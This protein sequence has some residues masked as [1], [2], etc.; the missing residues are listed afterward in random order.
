MGGQDDQKSEPT[1]SASFALAGALT[2]LTPYL[3]QA[4]TCH[5]EIARVQ[6]LVDASVAGTAE[7]TDLRESNFATMHRQPTR[8]S[9][10]KA[11]AEATGKAVALLDQAR[12]EEAAGHNAQCLKTLQIYCDAIARPDEF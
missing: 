4:E 8:E 9:V 5:D 7:I 3:A 11:K 2:L 6:K 1:G 10:A 12:K